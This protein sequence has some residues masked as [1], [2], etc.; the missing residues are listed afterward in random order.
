MPVII[1]R[2]GAMISYLNRT[3]GRRALAMPTLRRVAHTK[4]CDEPVWEEDTMIAMRKILCLLAAVACLLG[5]AWAQ[6]QTSELHVLVKDAKG[7]MVRGAT[8]TAAEAGKGI[9][10]TA[11]TNAEGI[12]ILLSL[13]P[14]PYSVTVDAPGFAK[15]VNE[16]VRLTIGQVA[17]LTVELSVA[18]AT[19][20]ITVSSQAQ[21]VEATQ[22]ASGTTIDQTRIDNLP[23]NGRNYVNFALTNSQLTRDTTPSIGAAP[24]SGLN[25]GGQRA[26]SNL[27]NIDGTDAT[28][29]S[30]NG[31]R[32]T[33]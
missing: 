4:S 3:A 17:E 18:A 22:T 1:E 14:G 8:I 9:S 27:V 7:A 26:R 11:T 13:P 31:I 21:M 29:N 24:T 33:V 32:S 23:I 25:I 6:V 28:D 5:G 30:V 20:T 16:S 19:E 15:M 10:R 12:A 2:T